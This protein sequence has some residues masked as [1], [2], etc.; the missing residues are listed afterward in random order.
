[1]DTMIDNTFKNENIRIDDTTRQVSVIDVI[2]IVNPGTASN[3]AGE[4]LRNMIATDQELAQKI[5]YLKIN[6]SGKLVCPEHM[7][8]SIC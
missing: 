6:D 2:R 5:E 8:M 1:M 4:A 3:H 7:I